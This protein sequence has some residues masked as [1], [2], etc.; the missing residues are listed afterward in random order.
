M[1][2]RIPE[3]YS[4]TGFDG[5]DISYY[6]HPSIT[7]IKQPVVEMARETIRILFEM[8]ENEI[9]REGKIFSADFVIGQSTSEAVVF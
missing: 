4:V 5:I 8:I 7:T 2:K 3:D 6:Y 9:E 1:G